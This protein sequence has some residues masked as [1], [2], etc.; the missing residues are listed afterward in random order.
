MK[1]AKVTQ[2]IVTP[3]KHGV[4]GSSW[5]FWLKRQHPELSIRQAKGLKISKVQGLTS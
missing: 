1:V 2:I 5:W 3:F 4:P